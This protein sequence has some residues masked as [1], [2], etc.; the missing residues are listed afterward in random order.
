MPQYETPHWTGPP[1]R[2]ERDVRSEI[3]GWFARYAFFLLLVFF[4]VLVGAALAFLP[5][6]RNNSQITLEGSEGD[7]PIAR[8]PSEAA[9]EG[10]TLLN[11]S[12]NPAG[13]MVQIDVDSI[14]VT[15]LYRRPLERKV[16]LLSIVK[17]GYA[18]VDTVLFADNLRSDTTSFFFVLRPAPAGEQPAASPPAQSPVTVVPQATGAVTSGSDSPSGD[19]DP[20]RSDTNPSPTESTSVE[21]TVGSLQVVSNPSGATVSLDGRIVGATPIVVSDVDPGSRTVEIFMDGYRTESTAVE[22]RPGVQ[23]RITTDLAAASGTLVVLAR[24]YG[25]IYIDGKLA[26]RNLDIEYRTTIPVGPHVI[27]VSHPVLGE[28]KKDIVI[29]EGESSLLF[30]FKKM[31]VVAN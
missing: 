18:R 16:H 10:S 11:V 15:P 22:V 6:L 8:H 7:S 24:P 31:E 27:T 5:S 25:T 1:P 13:A 20:R 26:E 17:K 4:L 28:L 3:A 12:T 30:D 2:P 9:L 19:A 21:V 14:G 23:S 29:N